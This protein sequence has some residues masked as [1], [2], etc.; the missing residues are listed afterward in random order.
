MMASS[1]VSTRLIEDIPPPKRED[2]SRW[3]GGDEARRAVYN[4]QK[5]YL[6]HV[7]GYNSG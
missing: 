7:A 6:I 3:H 2:L 5:R 4:I 1:L